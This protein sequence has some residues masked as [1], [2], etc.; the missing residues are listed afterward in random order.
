MTPLESFRQLV[1][2]DRPLALLD[3]AAQVP[4]YADTR[5]EPD[6]VVRTVRAWGA[7]LAQRVPADSSAN[8]R[9][10]LLNH[11]FFEELG[12]RAN[13]ERYNEPANS[14]LHRVIERRSGIPITLSLL[15][16]EIGRAAGLRLLGVGFPGHF[17][18][19]LL[20]HHG[21]MLVDVFGGGVLLSAD[22]LR[23]RLQAAMRGSETLP[24]EVYL[25]PAS[26]RDILARLLRNL[27]AIHWN[28]GEWVAALEVQQRL[29]A[30]LPDEPV[31]RRDRALLYER[32]ECPRAAA[33]DLVAYLSMRPDPQ[34]AREMRERLM[35]LQQAARQLN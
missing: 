22:K 2:A 33:D 11:Y 27:K 10:R 34:D 5:F 23:E 14:H 16:I 21:A 35:H 19:K 31:E 7:R 26:E 17:L 3:C 25:R 1:A 24:L 18:V 32:L 12:F 9:L 20:V 4:L 13:V 28:V 29:V 15:Y 30:V 8:N 6:A